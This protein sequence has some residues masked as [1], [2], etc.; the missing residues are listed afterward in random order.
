MN[1]IA[2]K[3]NTPTGQAAYEVTTRQVHLSVKDYFEM[4]INVS[5]L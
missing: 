2:Y 3:K 1:D 5:L 4:K